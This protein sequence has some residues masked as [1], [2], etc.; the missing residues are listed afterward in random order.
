M[1]VRAYLVTENG[2][3]YNDEGFYI[4]NNPQTELVY[5]HRIFRSRHEAERYIAEQPQP[6]WRYV[7]CNADV[8]NPILVILEVEVAEEETLIRYETLLARGEGMQLGMWCSLSLDQVETPCHPPEN[9]I[10]YTYPTRRLAEVATLFGVG[11]YGIRHPY[12]QADPTDPSYWQCALPRLSPE[13]RVKLAAVITL[14]ASTTTPEKRLL[15]FLNSLG[16]EYWRERNRDYYSKTGSADLSNDQE[17]FEPWDEFLEQFPDAPRL[18]TW[19][20]FRVFIFQAAKDC[21]GGFQSESPEDW[22]ALYA[23]LTPIRQDALRESL[24]EVCLG[25]DWDRL[26]AFAPSRSIPKA[27]QDSLLPLDANNWEALGEENN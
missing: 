25:I 24:N 14:A 4:V 26:R 13:I 11:V 15:F 1:S 23:Q 5:P 17:P 21:S 8:T 22:A 18:R 12:Q 3:Q 6:N 10:S 16:S 2:F 20:D 19:Q 9:R 27:D 7:R